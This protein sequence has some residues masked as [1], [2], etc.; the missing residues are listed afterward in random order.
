MDFTNQNNRPNQPMS[1]PQPQSHPVGE[2]EKDKKSKSKN[3]KLGKFKEHP[4]LNLTY[5]GMLL[6]ITVIIVG[7]V[8][9]I[10]FYDNNREEKYVDNSKYQAVFLNGGQVY[11]GKLTDVNS[12]FF[13][14]ED[15]YYL[16]VAQQ[17]QPDET[18]ANNFT[19]AKL[20]CELHRPQDSMQIN[21]DQIIFWE[22]LNDDDAQNSVPGAIK[23]YI[24]SNPSTDCAQQQQTTTTPTTT[25]TAPSTDTT[26]PDSG[27]TDTTPSTDGS[28]TPATP[29][30]DSSTGT[31]TGN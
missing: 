3:G 6:S 25:D 4:F 8:L 18:S 17:V 12:R 7:V 1:N 30:P 11:F 9:A 27:S 23:A 31:G 16:Q 19:L 2:P 13:A 26:T 5:L 24:A 10:F 21:R 28:T 22:N 14:L 29:P 20:G 15:I